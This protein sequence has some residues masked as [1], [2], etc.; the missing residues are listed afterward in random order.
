MRGI[1]AAC[2]I[3]CL[4]AC[5]KKVYVQEENVISKRK[6][7]ISFEKITE[8]LILKKVDNKPNTV[9]MKL[10]KINF[11]KPSI[12]EKYS[13]STKLKPSLK[14]ANNETFSPAKERK[15][16][17]KRRQKQKAIH[18]FFNDSFNI[19]I[20]FLV[21][22]ITMSIL[23]L[24]DLVLIFALASIIFLF[25]GLKKFFRWRRRTRILR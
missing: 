4:G 8:K 25:L 13:N 24:A 2:L 7:H 21:V 14:I 16:F 17:F 15:P 22:A 9:E 10:P 3:L 19:G 1:I 5:Q 18:R 6:V 20:F 23:N 12:S 11:A